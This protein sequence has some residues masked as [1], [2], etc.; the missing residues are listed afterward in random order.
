MYEFEC[1]NNN[2]N[3]KNFIAANR[4]K[5]KPKDIINEGNGPYIAVS[6]S[7]TVQLLYSPIR[8]TTHCIIDKL[9]KEDNAFHTVLTCNS[10]TSDRKNGCLDVAETVMYYTPEQDNI[11][12]FHAKSLQRAELNNEEK[13]KGKRDIVV[14]LIDPISLAIRVKTDLTADHLSHEAFVRTIRT[15]ASYDTIKSKL[16]ENS[17]LA[18]IDDKEVVDTGHD[19][20]HYLCIHNMAII[21]YNLLYKVDI[22]NNANIKKAKRVT[23][24]DFIETLLGVDERKE[25]REKI[26]N[27]REAL[28]SILESPLFTEYCKLF[29]ETKTPERTNNSLSEQELHL[30]MLIEIKELIVS[31]FQGLSLL[32]ESR[33]GHIDGKHIAQFSYNKVIEEGESNTG[34]DFDKLFDSIANE[35]CEIGKLLCKHVDSEVLCGDHQTDTKSLRHLNNLL[36]LTYNTKVAFWRAIFKTQN[37]TTFKLKLLESNS[38][39]GI[40]EVDGNELRRTLAKMQRDIVDDTHVTQKA[41]NGRIRFMKDQGTRFNFDSNNFKLTTQAVINNELKNK[42]HYRNKTGRLLQQ[43]TN[44]P[45][46]MGIM[47]SLYIFTFFDKNTYKSIEGG[48]SAAQAG[49]GVAMLTIMVKEGLLETQSGLTFSQRLSTSK[50]L[51]KT[52]NKLAGAGFLLDMGHATYNGLSQYYKEDNLYA[53][54]ASAGVIVSSGL[55]AY[56]TIKASMVWGWVGLL[57]AIAAFGFKWLFD[58]LKYGDME[59][60]VLS[61]IFNN[62]HSYSFNYSTIRDYHK[63]IQEVATNLTK[64]EATNSG[65]AYMSNYRYQLEEFLMCHLMVP[66]FELNFEFKSQHLLYSSNSRRPSIYEEIN[67]V[68]I[69]LSVGK[70]YYN[71]QIEEAEIIP[72]YLPRPHKRKGLHLKEDILDPYYNNK[73]NV[74]N[75]TFSV[76]RTSKDNSSLLNKFMH[77]DEAYILTFFRFFGAGQTMPLKRNH[78]D[79]YLV[80]RH[81]ITI[82]NYVGSK[83]KDYNNVTV[84]YQWA[85]ICT[86]EE[87]FIK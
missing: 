71:Q 8:L 72:Y 12:E 21:L 77:R 19:L 32:P 22:K 46:Y 55:A 20:E 65:R 17:S 26:H 83:V 6:E 24:K 62:K 73:A 45:L 2:F 61:T 64:Q 85:R 86:F 75:Y 52:F 34:Y 42:L 51:N 53:A 58:W 84:D 60:F 56:S 31:L 48:I 43:L 1:S 30:E 54:L 33:D 18:N 23:N 79:V 70:E 69:N 29:N 41:A 66:R 3:K 35:T 87:A 40:F 36:I 50:A 57:A 4:K 49:F 81:K 5:L 47:S 27:S 25:I 10:W 13:P 39:Y 76:G 44:N 80:Y 59:K 63:D 11:R 74:Y 37:R 67:K 38:P 82:N 14:L 28:A 15:G 68:V 7:D 78:E 9:V 16:I